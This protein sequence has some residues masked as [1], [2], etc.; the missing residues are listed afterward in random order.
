MIT[1]FDIKQISVDVSDNGKFV[2]YADHKREIFEQNERIAELEKQVELLESTL[3]ILAE[4]H[5]K[6]THCGKKK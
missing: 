5:L 1:R 4:G 3:R 2:Y 6:C